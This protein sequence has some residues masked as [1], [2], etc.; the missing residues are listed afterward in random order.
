MMVFAKTR[1]QKLRFDQASLVVVMSVI[2]SLTQSGISRKSSYTSCMCPSKHAL[3]S[4]HEV[5]F[6][7]QDMQV[8][9]FVQV[10][11]GHADFKSNESHACYE[12]L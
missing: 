10:M 9:K 1:V 12:R 5:I 2:Y 3:H 11:K 4:S 6:V 8:I 7:M